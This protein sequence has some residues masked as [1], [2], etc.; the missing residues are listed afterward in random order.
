[1]KRPTVHVV[2]AG[3]SGLSAAVRLAAT[4]NADIVVHES[5]E[6]AGGRRR[7]FFDEAMAMTLDCGHDL[8]LSSWRSAWAAIEAVGARAQ[9]REVAPDGV[10]FADMA[11]GERWTLRP[12]AGPF[13]WW[14]FA[15]RR[16]APRT[17]L[18]DYWPAAWL[19]RAPASALL[20]DYAPTGGPAAERL[21]RPF[22][23][24]ALNT[25]LERASARL[26]GVALSETRFGRA[27]PLMPV[28]G[29]ARAF[30]EPAVKALRRRDVAVRFERRLA[31]LDLTGER[32]AGLEFEHDRV[33]LAPG[34]AVILATPAWVAAALMPGLSAPQ[35]FN[36]AITAH[37]AVSPPPGA[38]AIL[39]V[40]NGA[41]HWMFC[42]DDRISAAIKDA[43]ALMESPREELA[44]DLWRDVAA[45]TGL[46]DAIPAWRIIRQKR[47]TFA[48]TP[49]QDALRPSC[50]TPWRN[51]FLAGAY[52]QNGLP[53]SLESAVRSGAL[54]AERA[55]KWL[56]AR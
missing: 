53:D 29:L 38:P 10:A 31:A 46:S 50:E 43:D 7:S 41:F 44:A 42:R 40:V 5:A 17:R 49:E 22:A 32:V 55:R 19:G 4:A 33:D 16:R 28:H 37:F 3:F 51:L 20:S 24:A 52:V 6:Q 8:A 23:L 56:E 45:L 34:D 21:W 48:A 18:K 35:E 36:G 11:S 15:P 39:G 13:P 1:M 14:V 9:W 25:D 47:A 2:G 27:R 12:N 26:A 30:V 54:A